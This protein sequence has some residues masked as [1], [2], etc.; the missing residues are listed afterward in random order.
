MQIH[1]ITKRRPRTDE[2]LLDTLKAGIAGAKA[3]GQAAMS[4]TFGA[5]T[6]DQGALDAAERSRQA[7]E[8]KYGITLPGAK[9]GAGEMYAGQEQAKAQAQ[10]QTAQVTQ[11]AQAATQAFTA[12]PEFNDLSAILP[13]PGH[14]LVLNATKDGAKYF[15]NE[16]GKWFVKAAAG[17]KTIPLEKRNIEWAEQQID[18]DQYGQEAFTTLE[19]ATRYNRK[20]LANASKKADAI[21]NKTALAKKLNT[22]VSQIATDP[23]VKATVDNAKNILD[24]AISTTYSVDKNAK[25]KKQKVEKA[26]QNYATA[27]LQGMATVGQEQGSLGTNQ[28]TQGQVS[29]PAQKAQSIQQLKQKGFTD[30]QIQAM[31]K[32]PVVGQA[33]N[34]IN[35]IASEQKKSLEQRLSE[36]LSLINEDQ[37]RITKDITVRTAGGNYVK[38]ASDQTWYDPKGVAI[39]PDKYATYVKKLDGTP[40]AQTQYQ[41]DANKGMTSSFQGTDVGFKAQ[42]AV[43]QAAAKTPQQS[44]APQAAPD[45]VQQIADQQKMAAIMRSRDVAGLNAMINDTFNQLQNAKIFN[46]GQEP[47]LKDRMAQ[48]MAMKV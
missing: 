35:P 19:E 10:A 9:R 40:Q 33:I 16:N 34:L 27:A 37:V 31:E 39:D 20:A 44:A 14:V 17:G 7:I 47:Y 4:P 5:V 24:K 38:R 42:Q 21:L 1:D 46:T 12:D 48:L 11:Q 8:K 32:D 3:V 18:Q 23:K 26:F 30:P 45:P 6:R 41:A 25:V 28:S 15:K 13:D 43:S 36:A 22:N 29:S 2:G